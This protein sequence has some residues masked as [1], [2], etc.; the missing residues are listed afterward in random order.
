MSIKENNNR[1]IRAFWGIIPHIV[2]IISFM[3][4]GWSFAQTRQYSEQAIRYY[5][6]ADISKDNQ[7]IRQALSKKDEVERTE[8][9]YSVLIPSMVVIS[10]IIIIKYWKN[11]NQK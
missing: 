5:V 1:Y 6:E 4:I 9:I 2:V 10:D 11:K 8:K 3:A 7:V